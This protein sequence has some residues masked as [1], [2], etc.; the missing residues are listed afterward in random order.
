MGNSIETAT[1]ED[2]HEYAK[3]SAMVDVSREIRCSAEESGA[4]TVFA[5][6]L[7][8]VVSGRCRSAGARCRPM[9][10]PDQSN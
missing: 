3:L 4:E 1:A 8:R 9:F 6:V 10:D 5:V 2:S 7:V